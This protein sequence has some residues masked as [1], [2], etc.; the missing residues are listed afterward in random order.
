MM[1][2]GWLLLAFVLVQARPVSC[3]EKPQSLTTNEIKR[4]IDGLVSPN[5]GPDERKLEGGETKADGGFPR[6]YD[7]KK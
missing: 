3:G 5:P 1:R 7:H 2:W 6:D 4:L